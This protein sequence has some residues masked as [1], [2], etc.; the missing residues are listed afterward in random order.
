MNKRK[1]SPGQAEMSFFEVPA[2]PRSD[3]GS[4]DVAQAV[5]DGLTDTLATAKAEGCDRYDIAA[6]ISRLSGRDMSKDMLDRYTASSS[7]G[8][9]FPLEALPAL[10]Q[11]TGDFRLLE[12]IAQKCGC[13]ILRGEEAVLAEI[14]ALMLQDRTTK[15][16]LDHI[17]KAV[18]NSVMDRL[19]A[20]VLERM[21]NGR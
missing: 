21:G 10:V 3:A 9:R 5:R 13:K 17:K 4:L 1:K 7:D 2:T 18:P 11:A 20:E 16:R 12:L 14:G 15:A 19:V 6:S 8:H